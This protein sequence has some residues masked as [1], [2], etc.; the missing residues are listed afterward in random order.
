MQLFIS[1]DSLFLLH[2][3]G[4]DYDNALLTATFNA[5]DTTT[6]VVIPIV[7]DNIEE[8]DEEL[9]LT[10]AISSLTGVKL[11][12]LVNANAVIIDTS[13]VIIAT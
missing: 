8:E 11:G 7:N 9:N 4:I 13:K 5:G 6:T 1:L 12:P 10:I 3:D 2:L